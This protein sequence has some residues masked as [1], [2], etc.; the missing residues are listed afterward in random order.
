MGNH[1]KVKKLEYRNLGRTGVKVSPLCLGTMNFGSRTPET[2]A[3]EIIN[4]AI[5]VG[6]N[7]IDTANLYGDANEGVGRSEEIIGEA[8]KQNDKRKQLVLA[9]KVYFQMDPDD[10]NSSGLSR[11]H[12]ISECEASLERLG[13]N[14]I[15][16][17][18]LHRPSKYIP[19]DETLRGLDDLIHNGK[20]RYIGT[21][22]FQAWQIIEG[23]WISDKLLLNRFV[24]EQHFYNMLDRSI[25]KN[26]IPIAQKYDIG[27]LPYS[28]L[29]GGILTGKYRRNIPFPNDTRFTFEPWKGVWDCDLN[30]AVYHLLD[31]ITEIIEEKSCTMSQFALAWLMAQPRITSVIIGPRTTEQLKENLGALHVKLTK[32]DLQRIDAL[33]EPGTSLI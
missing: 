5:D 25:E 28:P 4:Q 14:Y 32:S 30:E 1:E 18:Q 3:I 2:K 12:I 6:L 17:Y 21:S 8:L 11:R 19:I 26:I 13:T 7:F 24:T 15:D 16:L 31:E 22:G 9:T 23:L 20:I 29:D 33:V 27:I 10:P